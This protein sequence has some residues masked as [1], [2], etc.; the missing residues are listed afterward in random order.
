MPGSWDSLQ[1]RSDRQGGKLRSSEIS[2]LFKC[3]FKEQ[4]PRGENRC[5]SVQIPRP[6]QKLKTDGLLY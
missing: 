5:F 3:A 6:T 4:A 2:G 1:G